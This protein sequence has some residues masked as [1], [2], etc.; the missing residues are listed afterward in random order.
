MRTAL[1][2]GDILALEG[3][4]RLRDA[5]G[6]VD[7]VMPVPGDVHSALLAAG[8]I[9]D[10]YHADNEEAV[11]WVGEAEWTLERT[12]DVPPA[13]LAAPSVYLH[14]DTL[15][16]LCDVT[17]NGHAA[18]TAGSRFRRHR[19]EVR[20]FLQPGANIVT[21]RFH[22]A[23]AAMRARAAALPYPV[24]CSTHGPKIPHWNL[25]RKPMCHA[26]WDWGPALQ[27][28]AVLG[29]ISLRATR[30]ARV[31]HV[32]T[33]QTFEGDE[34]CRVEVFVEAYAPEN[35]TVAWR[36]ECDGQTLDADARLTPGVNLLSASLWVDHP[37]RWWPHGAGEQPLYELRVTV[38]EE[39]VVRRIGLRTLEIVTVPDRIGRPL[40]VRVNGTDIFC[41]GAN[42]IPTD[43]LPARQTPERT[44]ALIAAARAA[45]MNILR[46]WGG[47]QYEDDAFY[48]ACDEAG[49][50][51]WQDC[52]FACAMYPADGPFLEEVTR[53][54]EFQGKRLRDHPSLALWCGDNECVGALHWFEESRNN[55]DRYLLDWDRL[56]TA[57]AAALARADPT[58]T[59][60]PSSPCAGPGDFADTF[61]A[62]G[63]GDMHYWA[64]WHE[65]K[66]FDAYYA[67]RP[68][69]CS[70]F[71]YQSFPSLET[72]RTFCP[73]GE[74]NVTAPAMEFHQRNDAGNRRIVEMFSRYFRLP[75]GFEQTLYLSQVQQAWAIKTAVEWWRTLRPECMGTIYWQLNDVWPGASW[76]SLEYGGKWKQLHHH[77][78]RFYAPVTACFLPR[79]EAV[80]LWTVNDGAAAE[81]WTA[82]VELWTFAGEILR[83][84]TVQG[85]LAAGAA[86]L[87]RRWD[88]AELAPTPRDRARRFLH[89]EWQG[90]ANTHW[91]TEPKRCAL[92]AANVQSQLSG[93]SA[94]LA[95]DAPAFFVWA[96]TPGVKGEFDDNSFTLLPGRPRTLTFAPEKAG[97]GLADAPI[98]MHLAKCG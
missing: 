10:P 16:T 77:A 98:I 84:E 51:V 74:L 58:R 72:V 82:R 66:S 33:R 5:A 37:R 8:L 52:M 54:L 55:R 25:L 28:V 50:L 40:T 31:E 53:E 3:D 70:E 86:S 23:P 34:R 89:V 49:L 71:G 36:V 75:V 44:R 90:G 39:T 15:D 20:P 47:G 96:D 13:L 30:T 85:S 68:R 97:D 2:E 41:K 73:P 65:G 19:W 64:V 80:E 29:E 18:G 61:H 22:S 92:A 88:V 45:H 57:R 6:K 87:Q 7:G 56:N 93:G 67:V 48:E 60:W 27:V 83:A 38:G 11:Q 81:E 24:P 1:P 94:A 26:G 35:A 62:D 12:V 76:S 42:W 59:Y 69:F 9:P 95:T 14:A 79:G 43:A 32:Y 17:V 91:F 21:L 78:R 63:S 4:W 46:V